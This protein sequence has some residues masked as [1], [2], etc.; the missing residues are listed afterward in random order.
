ML[1]DPSPLVRQALAETLADAP[2]APRHL[3][4]ALANDQS[5]IAT[6]V[7]ARSPVLLD[8]DLID[9]AALG[10]EP[11]QT[12]IARRPHVSVA[13]SAALAEI[14]AAGALTVLAGN[15]GAEIADASL[16]RMVERHG[17]DAGLSQAL[18]RRPHLP[19]DIR[20]AV[21][22]V[23]SDHLSALVTERG[24]AGAGRAE[25]TFSDARDRATIAMAATATS[26]DVQRLVAYL[27]RSGQLTPALL[28]R[29]LLSRSTALVEAA[30]ADLTRIPPARVAGLLHDRRGAGFPALYDRAGLPKSLKPAFAAAISAVRDET[31]ADAAL[32]E[33]QL[34]PHMIERVLSACAGLPPDT[35]GQLMALLR[36]YEVEA[37][38]DA[39]REA[40]GVLAQDA[41]VPFALEYQPTA[42][43]EADS[44]RLRDAA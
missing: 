44:E 18:L 14:A 3:V 15:A 8:A 35:T 16:W 1:D 29:A 34:S 43:I 40:I 38:R 41:A 30:F 42:L 20:H 5:E 39:A 26:G 6:V 31:S 11:V 23:A 27:R 36:R 17:S 33:A 12:A 21:A 28:L 4:I 22:V 19:L 10:D 24:W 2:E 37:A 13:A 25:R 32:P 7:L 9:C